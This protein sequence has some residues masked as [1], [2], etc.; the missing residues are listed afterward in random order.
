[1]KNN[2]NSF[3]VA[4][5]LCV[6]ISAQCGLGQSFST[7][8]PADP[9]CTGMSQ[10]D[11]AWGTVQVSAKMSCTIPV[12]VGGLYNITILTKEPLSTILVGQRVFS[13]TLNGHTISGVDIARV[14]PQ[15]RTYEINFL[16]AVEQQIVIYFESSVRTAVWTS[17]IV[18]PAI[19]APVTQPV[20]PPAQ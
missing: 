4:I 11:P 14:S 13:I 18:R 5:G 9:R 15:T 20:A 8:A 2:K 17:I 10:S 12:P 3:I 19:D 16:V 1:M 6:G 7:V